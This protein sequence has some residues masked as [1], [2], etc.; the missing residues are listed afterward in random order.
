MAD[1]IVDLQLAEAY[2]ESHT[3]DFED[4]S[5]KLVIKQSI[6][7]K[8]GITQQDYD[9]SLVWYAHNMEDYN[10]AF[11]KAARVLNI[12]YPGGPLLDKLAETGDPHPDD[13]FHFALLVFEFGPVKFFG[14]N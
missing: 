11:D 3:A 13:L 10:K 1:L 2:I 8:H 9:S 12:P 5:S 6:F 7:K 14:L 4:D